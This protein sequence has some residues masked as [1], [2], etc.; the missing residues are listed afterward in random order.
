MPSIQEQL[1]KDVAN[2][3]WQDLLPHAKRDA[4]IVV[5]ESLNLLDVA[6]AIAED[7]TVSVQQWINNKSIS[8]PSSEQLTDWNQ[9][10]QKQFVTVIVQPFVI[11]QEV[12][13]N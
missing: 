9:E 1:S 13:Q 6:I 11:I 7:N 12:K 4:I 10:M 5:A 3:N 8:K 2:I